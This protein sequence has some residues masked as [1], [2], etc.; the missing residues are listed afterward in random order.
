M[1]QKRVGGML[2]L[3]VVA[4]MLS[5][6]TG[7]ASTYKT[8]YEFKGAPDAG[9]PLDGLIFDAAGN[10][11]GT[12]IGGGA[13]NVGSVFK[14]APNA[15]GSWTES[16]LYSFY[17]PTAGKVD[18]EAPTA[19]LIFDAAGNLY[20]TTSVG[21]ESDGGGKCPNGCGTVFKLAPNSDGS[22][23][24]SVL[25]E[26]AGVSESTVDGSIPTA[27]L[28]FDGA[29]NLYGTTT[30]GGLEGGGTVFKLA[31]NA[32]GSWTES[33]LYTFCSLLNC[34]DGAEPHDSLVFDGGNLYG[35]TRSGG[36]TICPGGCGTVFKLAPNSDG[37]W[38][39]SVLHKLQNGRDGAFPS[40]GVILDPA[41]NL[42]GTTTEGGILACNVGCGT[43]F[44]LAPNSE[45]GW[46]ESVI[47]DFYTSASPDDRLLTFDAAGNLYGTTVVGGPVNDG[48]V[49]KLA[50]QPGG[51]WAYSV[52]RYFYGE[53][54]VSPTGNLVID[55]AGNLYGVTESCGNG[56]SCQGLVFEIT[57]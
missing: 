48:R 27:G 54:A 38:T 17:S 23:T 57:P 10:L 12:T 26:F 39:E 34:A 47:R 25:Y 21:G 14:L 45:G 6:S 35:T 44:K 28:I 36:S 52:L 40:S 5:T 9:Q 53:P 16:V 42:Y 24:E 50:P 51:G 37:T 41:G 20:G 7:A 15:D 13:Y 55:K 31:P 1:V 2:A 29:G 43:V 22:W 30:S 19:R 33:V 11:Y 3:L 8:L 4:F 18:G 56:Y 32:G 46:T 49:F